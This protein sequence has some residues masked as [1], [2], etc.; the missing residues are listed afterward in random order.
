M[1]LL[2][3]RVGAPP[4]APAVPARPVVVAAG[5]VAFAGAS[6]LL[7]HSVVTDVPV[8]R[9]VVV[10][11]SQSVDSGRVL[12]LRSA[13]D[14]PA[15]ASVDVP[16]RPSVV[17]AGEVL[18][19]G[20]TLVLRSVADPV[21]AA[22]QD[23]PPRPV[24]LRGGDAPSAGWVWVSRL[25]ADPVAVVDVPPVPRPVLVA[26]RA[27]PDPA[28]VWVLRPSTDPTA[29]V[30]ADAPPRPVVVRSAALSDP[31]R[32]WVLK[33]SPGPSTA[34]VRPGNVTG[35]PA[36]SGGVEAGGRVAAN[37]SAGRT[38]A[39]SVDAGSRASAN[40]TAGVLS[41][42][43][44]TFGNPLVDRSAGSDTDPR[45][46]GI[47]AGTLPAGTLQN[48]LTWNETGT[49]TPSAGFVFHAYVLRPTGV[50]NQYTVVFD[51]GALTV[52][53]LNV[54]GV[55][56]LQTWVVT[57]G[58]LAGDRL[59]W[60]GQGIPWSIGGPDAFE[61]PGPVSAP[62]LNDVVNFVA[63][64]QARIYSIAATIDPRT[65][66]VTG[67]AMAAPTVRGGG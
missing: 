12:V 32:V 53:A 29:A 62:V 59:G 3:S 13:V 1:S 42:S 65:P 58:V 18:A 34:L 27:A 50:A 23:V 10:A 14:P 33:A 61:F 67:V 57:T 39:A 16:P 49:P 38:P 21:V 47:L 66:T 45:V 20:R 37:V 19:S 43:S 46:L 40:V 5:M 24:V 6:V 26:A 11:G 25:R 48:V 9:P 15:A 31:A 41:T 51:S 7:L 63:F 35:G 2:L 30:V 44:L 22:A 56:Q 17:R 28:R 60:Y 4:S 55:S 8:P 52:P 36:P 54:P 64:G